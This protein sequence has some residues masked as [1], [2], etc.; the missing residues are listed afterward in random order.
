MAILT[1]CLLP[2][3]LRLPSGEPLG[4][5]LSPRR[6]LLLNRGLQA[7]AVGTGAGIAGLLQAERAR[8]DS[9]PLPDPL[10]DEDELYGLQSQNE[11]APAR[12]S[13]E[14]EWQALRHKR[15]SAEET[16]EAFRVVWRLRDAIDEAST[17]AEAR[18]WDELEAVLPA[19][20]APLFERAATVLAASASL[21]AQERAAIGWEWGACGWRRC[22]AQADV[23]QALA[24]LRANLGM[25]VPLEALFYLDVAKRGADEIIAIGVAA[26]VRALEG[27]PST[28]GCEERACA[29]GPCIGSWPHM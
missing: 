19:A 20:S 23:S 25:I 2:H 4:T 3:A 27:G 18:R 10:S 22:G 13:L 16:R 17:L 21:G 24:K 6:R 14:M 12:K 28:A 15:P 1:M 7:L 26:Q 11:L 9:A 8:L 29:P 5:E